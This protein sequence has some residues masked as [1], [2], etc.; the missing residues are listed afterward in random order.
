LIAARFGLDLAEEIVGHDE[1]RPAI[2]ETGVSGR[3]APGYS[4]AI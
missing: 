4:D 3:Y 2:P 1:T